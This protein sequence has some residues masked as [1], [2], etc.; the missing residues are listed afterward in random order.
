MEENGGERFISMRD[1]VPRLGICKSTIYSMIRS[2]KFPSGMQ[3]S[4]RRVGW[5]SSEVTAWMNERAI[6]GR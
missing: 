6:G 4:E 3:I 2:G 5:L 1:L